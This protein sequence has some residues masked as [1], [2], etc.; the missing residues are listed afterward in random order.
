MASRAEADLL[1]APDGTQRRWVQP[2]GQIL[3]VRELRTHMREEL[4]IG[5]QSRHLVFVLIGGELVET[6][7]N[8]FAELGA[9]AHR[10]LCS[11]DRLQ[12][13]HISVGHLLAL[14]ADEGR[15]PPR[16]KVAD[17]PR[18]RAACRDARRC[19]R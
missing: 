7:R 14:V 15:G 11:P 9:V 17:L 18:D 13:L 4:R 10:T 16:D 1:F 2:V 12:Q 19:R 3:A 5:Q 6:P 8:G